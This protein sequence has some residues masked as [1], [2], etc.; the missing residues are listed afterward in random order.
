MIRKRKKLKPA[1]IDSLIGQKSSVSGDLKFSG[2]LH[3][4]GAI[5]GDVFA[6]DA[7]KSFLSISNRGKIEGDV[8]V[9]HIVLNGTVIGDVKSSQHIELAASAR[10]EGNVFYSLIEMAMGAEVNGQLVHTSDTPKQK[11]ALSHESPVDDKQ[12]NKVHPN[13]FAESRG[14]SVRQRIV[15]SKPT[16]R[17]DQRTM[18]TKPATKVERRSGEVQTD[19]VVERKP[20]EKA[21]QHTSLDFANMWFGQKSDR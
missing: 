1:K 2:G 3:V 5:K 10:V 21:K 19:K 9:P 13:R 7:D 15:D 14:A 8:R 16:G 11:L 20:T 4:D 12:V 18:E 17:T 6:D